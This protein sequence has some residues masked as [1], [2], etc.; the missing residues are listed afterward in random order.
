MSWRP[1]ARVTASVPALGFGRSSMSDSALHVLPPSSDDVVNTLPCR[2]R[3]SAC[4]LFPPAPPRN[5]M[6]G[7]IAAMVRPSLS[8][9]VA[10]HVLPPS[11]LRSKCT[12][13]RLGSSSVSVLVGET[14]VPSA[15][16]TG[17]FLIGPR[18]P[19]GRRRASLHVRP[20][21]VL[22]RSIPH[23]ASG[24]GPTL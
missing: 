2:D 8:G 22:V 9:G 11:L 4:S 5:R 23:Q 10:V 24:D 16:C 19:S 14:M 15:S 21:S 3:P 17:L 12:R 7:W 1:S 6:L 13:Q 20:P 18:M